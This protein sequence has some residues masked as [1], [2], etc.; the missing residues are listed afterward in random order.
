MSEDHSTDGGTLP[1]RTT[2]NKLLYLFFGNLLSIAFTIGLYADNSDS[3]IVRIYT[4]ESSFSDSSDHSSYYKDLLDLIMPSGMIAYE[5]QI[6]PH[7]RSAHLFNADPRSCRLPSNL[8]TL[9]K[10]FGRPVPEKFIKSRAFSHNQVVVFS[11]PGTIPP[12]TPEDMAGKRIAAPT[13]SRY[14][15]PFKEQSLTI[16]HTD[17]DLQRTEILMA[18]RVDLM[19]ASLPSVKTIFRKLNGPWPV[20][21]PTFLLESYTLYLACHPTPQTRELIKFV[22]QRLAAAEKNGKLRQLSER[23]GRSLDVPNTKH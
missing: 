14:L 20:Y 3:H 1:L 21:D 8:R 15:Q 17:T 22:N 18:G 10:H 4:P 23:H 12:A 2:V 9:S 5:L 6:T 19:L 16:V 11:A 7:M 13:G